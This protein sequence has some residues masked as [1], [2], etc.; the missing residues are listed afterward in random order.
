MRWRSEKAQTMWI[1]ERASAASRPASSMWER[2]NSG[3]MVVLD[4]R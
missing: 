4:L 3:S 1:L 2:T